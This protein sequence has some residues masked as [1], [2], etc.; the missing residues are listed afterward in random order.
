SSF[1]CDE[2]WCCHDVQGGVPTAFSEVVPGSGRAFKST[3]AA[4]A[5]RS[6][7]RPNLHSTI[8]RIDPSDQPPRCPVSRVLAMPRASARGADCS[9]S[10]HPATSGQVWGGGKVSSRSELLMDPRAPRDLNPRPLD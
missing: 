7:S 3:T 6:S 1:V 2:D 10:E 8:G 9:S 5:L 4:S